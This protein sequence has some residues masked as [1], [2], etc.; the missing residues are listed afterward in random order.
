MASSPF[1]DTSH[2][3]LRSGITLFP[4]HDNAMD[5]ILADLVQHIPARFVLLTD[6]TGQVILAQGERGQSDLVAL[7]SLVAGDLAA[8]QEIARL[9][10]EY[11]NYQMIL[12]EGE[13]IHTFISEAGRYLI[14]LVQVSSS[15][16]LGWARIL[17]R[18]AVLRLAD[19]VASLPEDLEESDLGL[20]KEDLS[21]ELIGQALDDL[22]L[23]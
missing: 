9:T 4:A 8:S 10:G 6:V 15:V 17:I 23:E 1:M 14:L 18:E 5:L 21:A 11:Q 16:P 12:R 20:K 19:V 13:T 22:W 2:Y 3:N 7:G